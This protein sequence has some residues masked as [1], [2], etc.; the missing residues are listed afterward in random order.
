MALR[1][2]PSVPI[3]SM[4]TGSPSMWTVAEVFRA[5]EPRLTLTIRFIVTPPS[6]ALARSPRP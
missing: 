6:P 4:V 3:R 2:S 1:R 5:E